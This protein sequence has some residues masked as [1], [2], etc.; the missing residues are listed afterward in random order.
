M[1]GYSYPILPKSHHLE[2]QFLHVL[3]VQLASTNQTMEQLIA[4]HVLLGLMLLKRE[5]EMLRIASELPKSIR[6]YLSTLQIAFLISVRMVD[7]AE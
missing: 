1:E 5:Q 4:S 3:Y 7:H 2:C 6:H